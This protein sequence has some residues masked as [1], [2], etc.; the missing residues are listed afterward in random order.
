MASTVYDAIVIGA[1]SVGTPSAMY[2]AEKGLKVLCLDQFA[3]AGQG[4][5]KCAL[6]GIRA[7]HSA[8]AKI[9]LCLDSL[10]VFS[11]WQENHGHD[12]E[13][14]QGGYVFVAYREHEE[15]L[16]KDLLKI[17]KRAGLNIDWLDKEALLDVVP[18]LVT[19]GLVG[20]TYSPD[21]GGASPM[22]SCLA[23][24]DR[25][26]Q[27]GVDFRFNERVTSIMRR[28]GKV[29][30]VRTD[31]GGYAT[32]CVVN[33]AGPWARQVAQ[34]GGLDNL[35]VPDCHEG[36]ITEPVAPFLKPMVV[37]IR[38]A[39]GSANYY[40]YQHK[41]GQVIFC[42]TPLPGH[43]R[44]RPAGD[45]GIPADDLPAHGGPD[46]QAGQ[47]EDPPHLAGP[48]PDDPGR[49]PDHRQVQGAGR[50]RGLHRHVRP[51][52][53]AWPRRGQADRPD[54]HRRAAGR[55]RR[56]PG[57]AQPGPG[58]RRG[59]GAEVGT[60]RKRPPRPFGGGAAGVCGFS[61]L[62]AGSSCGPACPWGAA[63]REATSRDCRT[64]CS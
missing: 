50:L 16:L 47:P 22:R 60:R 32:D 5:N 40:F 61:S 51:G 39:P 7:T 23:F 1:G 63:R 54:R 62:P 14:Y 28:K 37:D 11:H 25:A 46:A 35:V 59:R 41:P 13:W 29:V 48:L 21:D 12:L 31:K 10:D 45:L 56:D 64:R 36:G 8:P 42:Y 2:L 19:E 57:R 20:G 34:A 17:Q 26:T 52:L 53:H 43:R 49:R 30:G 27:M 58:V 3:S 18:G 6:G 9:K 33:A 4:S 38:P 15:K 55:R 24:Q 44:F